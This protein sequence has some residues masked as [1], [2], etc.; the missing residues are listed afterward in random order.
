MFDII[1]S[2][3]IHS[4]KYCFVVVFSVKLFDRIKTKNICKSKK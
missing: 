3:K 1:K 4:V 2:V